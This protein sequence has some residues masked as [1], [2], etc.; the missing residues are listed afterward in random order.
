MSDELILIAF[1][2]VMTLL[3][4]I[5]IGRHFIIQERQIQRLENKLDALIKEKK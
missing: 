2:T 5:N 4:A 3:M 1:G